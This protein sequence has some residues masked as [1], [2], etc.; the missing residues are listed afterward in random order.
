MT[1]RWPW[2]EPC[3][4]CGKPVEPGVGEYSCWFGRSGPDKAPESGCRHPHREGT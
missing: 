2:G 1:A 4:V 3:V